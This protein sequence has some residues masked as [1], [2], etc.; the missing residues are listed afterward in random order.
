V[1]TLFQSMYSCPSS[2][3]QRD[4]HAAVQA[5][6]PMHLL[7]SMTIATCLLINLSFRDIP[8][9]SRRVPSRLAALLQGPRSGG[10]GGGVLLE[11]HRHVVVSLVRHVVRAAVADVA[12]VADQR[13]GLQQPGGRNRRAEDLPA[14]A[15]HRT[16]TEVHDHSGA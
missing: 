10:H 4:L 2:S 16:P 6:Q 14:A 11:V 7:R 13:G 8:E 9:R 3:V 1:S 12:V 15:N 5:W